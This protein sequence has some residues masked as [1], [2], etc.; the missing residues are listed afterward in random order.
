MEGIAGVIAGFVSDTE[1]VEGS[2]MYP[3]RIKTVGKAETSAVEVRDRLWGLELVPGVL[4]PNDLWGI[5]D[6]LRGR[7]NL[8][9]LLADTNT[10]KRSLAGDF[11]GGR[12]LSAKGVATLSEIA[13]A[14]VIPFT[15]TAIALLK[16]RIRFGK[17]VDCGRDVIANQVTAFNQ[18]I[19]D[20]LQGEINANPAQLQPELIAAMVS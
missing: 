3:M 2:G 11:L 6:V 16:W 17:A 19:L 18:G 12:L 10:N 9:L 14:A 4:S 8:L 7:G 15:C 13:D 1:A 20:Q 5:R